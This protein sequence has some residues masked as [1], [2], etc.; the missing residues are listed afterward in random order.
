M[1]GVCTKGS[2]F[3]GVEKTP[4]ATNAFETQKSTKNFK[5]M[6]TQN[7][8]SNSPHPTKSPILHLIYRD[9]SKN[10]VV[11][12]S[13]HVITLSFY[14]RI[15]DKKSSKRPPVGRVKGGRF[16]YTPT[17]PVG[18]ASTRPCYFLQL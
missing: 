14:C 9:A 15:I 11:L 3:R 2:S 1:L 12:K 10:P 18:P 17:P 8:I 6:P 4:C 7:A 5:K 16:L 13:L